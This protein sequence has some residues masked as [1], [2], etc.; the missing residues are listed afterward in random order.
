MKRDRFGDKPRFEPWQRRVKTAALSAFLL[1]LLVTWV[2]AQREPGSATRSPQSVPGAATGKDSCVTC[3]TTLQNQL[4]A[5]I[6]AMQDDVHAKHGLSCAGCHGGNPNEDD[7]SRSHDP[8]KGYVGKPKLKD[9]PQF[10]GKCHSN[11]EF[12]KTFNPALRVDQETEYFTS[13]HGKLSRQGDQNVATCSSCHGFHGIKA[14]NDP[15]APVYPVKVAETCGKCH[16]SVE[17]MRP[18]SIATDQVE[19]YSRS[20]HSEALMKKLDLSAPTC[21]DCHGNHGATPPGLTSV[22]N[23][24]GN[25]HSRQGEL[26]EKSPHKIP[27]AEAQLAACVVCHSN[28]EIHPPTDEMLGVGQEATCI[29]CHTDGDA[30]FKAAQGMRRQIDELAAHINTADQ[31]LSR[32]ARSG[33]EVARPQFDL[34]DARDKLVNARVVIHSFSPAQ[35]EA[36]TKPGVDVARKAL[37]AGEHSL[38]ELR[39]R[40]KG[41]AVSLVFILLTVV[42]VYF[43][44]RQIEGRGGADT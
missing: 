35:V 36:A 3:H 17:H 4:S 21:N 25:C 19:K 12:M 8:R 11:A 28:H 20:V 33:M 34:K 41:L 30:G 26:F 9:V 37:Q 14:V 39:R 27:F 32:A 18:Y 10:C 6:T 16:A 5:P 2:L 15:N 42:A 38:S 29:S 13:V 23:V 31:L 44:V 22:A 40:R 24:C 43:K 7:A 1:T